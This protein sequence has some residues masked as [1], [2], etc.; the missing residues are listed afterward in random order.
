MDGS[1]EWTFPAF[2]SM[3]AE[4]WSIAIAAMDDS[5]RA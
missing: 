3:S 4:T 1:V 5:E 2:R